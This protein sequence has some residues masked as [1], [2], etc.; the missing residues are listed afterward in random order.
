[1]LSPL[2]GLVAV[3]SELLVEDGLLFGVQDK[4]IIVWYRVS[5]IIER[6][7]AKMYLVTSF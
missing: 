2:D 6:F 5:G 7:M 3:A 1:M 4:Q